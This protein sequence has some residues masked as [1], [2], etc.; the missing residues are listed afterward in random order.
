MINLL[1]VTVVVAV[2][3]AIYKHYTVAQI[4]AEILKLEA[5]AV[6]DAK[7]VIAAIKAK[8]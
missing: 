7:I 4:A 5:A 3:Y 2:A 1:G 6:T 8:L